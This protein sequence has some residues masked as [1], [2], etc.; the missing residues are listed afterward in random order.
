[1]SLNW[2]IEEV[3]NRMGKDFTFPERNGE[4]RLNGRTEC[5][6]WATM[7]VDLG[8]IS[9]KNAKTFYQR[10]LAW[11]KINGTIASDDKPTTF[12]DVKDH[13]GLSTNVSN[14]TDT[15]FAKKLWESAKRRADDEARWAENAKAEKAEEA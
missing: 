12:Q 2:N 3:T 5:L 14:R 10:L 8:E 4:A 6:I 13:I 15:Q 11:E 1:M 7:F 9:E